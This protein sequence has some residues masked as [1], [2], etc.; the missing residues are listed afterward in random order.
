VLEQFIWRT[1]HES[2]DALQAVAELEFAR[3]N[4]Q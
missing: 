4:L 1:L 2:L 3:L